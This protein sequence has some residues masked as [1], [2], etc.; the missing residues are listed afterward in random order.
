[1]LVAYKK[2][3]IFRLLIAMFF[4]STMTYS[5]TVIILPSNLPPVSPSG[6]SGGG[7]TCTVTTNCFIAG[8]TTVSGT[9]SCTGSECQRTS[10]AVMC[11]G[12]ITTC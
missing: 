7:S 6:G 3:V 8:T 2:S 9:I 1:M 12:V 4:L 10:S 11:D 5:A